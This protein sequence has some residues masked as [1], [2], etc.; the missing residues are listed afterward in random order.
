VLAG[1]LLIYAVPGCWNCR[2]GRWC[3]PETKPACTYSRTCGSAGHRAESVREILTLGKNRQVTVFG[4][5]EATTGR[6]TCRL[7]R[8]LRG[9]LYRLAGHARR[10]VPAGLGDL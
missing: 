10:G 5:I 4:A 8:P 7:D 9:G 3:L 1:D 6:W 2:T